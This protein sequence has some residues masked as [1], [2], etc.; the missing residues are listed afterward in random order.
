MIDTSD[1]MKKLKKLWKLMEN[2]HNF[3]CQIQ[4]LNVEINLKQ[5]SVNLNMTRKNK[6][7]KDNNNDWRASIESTVTYSS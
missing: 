7:T 6:V 2:L 5:T 1:L 4:L 3:K